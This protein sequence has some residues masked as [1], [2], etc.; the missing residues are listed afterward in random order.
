MEWL[1]TIRSNLS[2]SAEAY[3]S[4]EPYPHIVI[5][6]FLPDSVLEK[7]IESFPRPESDIWT[8]RINDAYQVKL[9][10]NNVDSAP[11]PIRDLMYQLN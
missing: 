5:D 3:R 11:P 9:A 8:E 4:A 1:P 2:K 6:N 10:S 7:V